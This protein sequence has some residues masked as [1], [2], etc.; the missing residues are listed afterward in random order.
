MTWRAMKSVAVAAACWA[1]VTHLDDL[2]R[3]L[4]MRDLSNPDRY[5]PAHRDG[6]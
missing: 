4:R 5:P 2:A 3:F 6:A 1:V